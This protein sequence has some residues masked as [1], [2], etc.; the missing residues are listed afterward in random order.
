MSRRRNAPEAG[1]LGELD[2]HL[3]GEGRHEQ[4]YERLGA[5]VTEDG[6]RF[7][8]W[9]PN[10]RGVSVTGDW[11]GWREDADPLSP[12]GVSGIW[13]GV[14]AE[15]DEGN[16]YKLVVDGA[17]GVVRLKADPYAFQAEVPPATASV[18]HRSRH[19]WGDADWLERRRGLDPLVE[20]LSVYEVHAG[21]WRLGHGW[22][23]LATSL[24]DYVEELGFTH[25][26]LMPV[27]Q[28]PFL[29]SWGYQV[30]GYYAPQ[31][32]W[33]PPD[34]LRALIDALHRR[35]IGVLLDWVPAHFPRD[36]WALARFDGT[37]LYE[38]ADPRR[39]AH[40]DWGTLV[41]N[42]SRHEVRNF[43]LANA[44]YW[45]KE[46]HADGLRVDAVASMLYLDYSR[47]PGEWVPNEYGGRENLEAVTFLRELN[48]VVHGR[49]PG[50]IV[51]A[52]ESTAW[53]G[54]SRPTTTAGSASP[55]SGTWAG[56]TTRS[57]TSS[58][59]PSTAAST[60]TS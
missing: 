42:L 49:E 4:L 7:A 32:A 23:E 15:A 2:L 13:E 18:I 37:A 36:E 43:L 50:A 28:H 44:L 14:V 22:A 9:A 55:S 52:E 51:M 54:V 38:H 41:F 60:T 8:V 45:I 24:A 12:V 58:A 39:G 31:A 29:G 30:S 59:S 6:V 3:L 35:G 17:D 19:E 1:G 56:C 11:N 34:D 27:M 33:G 26:E 21:S 25:V 53:P 57:R 16:R 47:A 5:H 20:P 48:E 40:P 46:F 10:A